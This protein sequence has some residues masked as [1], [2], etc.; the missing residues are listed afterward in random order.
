MTESVRP[1]WQ[2]GLPIALAVLLVVGLGALLVPGLRHQV[3]L[4]A[5]HQQVSYTS[6]AFT[7]RPDGRVAGTL[8]PCRTVGHGG[9]RAAL[10][11][12]DLHAHG[13][14]VRRERWVV[15]VTDPA[16]HRPPRT[17]R[18]TSLVGSSSPSPDSSGP[19]PT[20]TVTRR[21]VVLPGRYDLAVILRGT[22]QRLLAH[23][24]GRS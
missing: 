15:R 10:V 6:L 23:C 18:G 2:R 16:G 24:G 21:V 20:V 3:A 7:P 11:R 12:F 4:S 13:D 9:T 22:T 19:G 1:W 8:A 14:D 5:S 17:V